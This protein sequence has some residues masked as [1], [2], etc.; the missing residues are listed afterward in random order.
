[1]LEQPTILIAMGWY[2]SR[3][4]RGIAHFAK[5]HNWHISPHL[6]SDREIPYGWR[7][8]GVLTSYSRE[9]EKFVDGLDIPYVV[10]SV[11]SMSRPAPRVTDDNQRVGQLAAEHYLERGFRHFAFFTWPDIPI[12]LARRDAYFAALRS[13]GVPAE[14]MHEILQP[15][16]EIRQDWARYQGSIIEQLQALPRPLAVF[17]SQDNMAA[18]IIDACTHNGIQVPEEIA[19]LGVDNIEFLCEC[20]A[21]PLSSIPTRQED[22]GWAAAKRLHQLMKGTITND[23]P[24]VLVPPKDVVCRRSTDVLAVEHP[25]VRQAVEFICGNLANPITLENIAACAGMSPRGLQKAFLK[26][27]GRSPADELRQCRLS[28]A[29]RLL[30]ETTDKVESIAR[31]CGYSNGANLSFALKRDCGLAARAYRNSFAPEA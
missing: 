5:E 24:P 12:N 4:F 11:V 14:A 1:M 6:F 26:H 23:A 30:M 8:D 13:A 9:Q 16:P 28:A 20:Q 22:I 15:P 29:K 2:D 25:A 31:N 19:V 3:L 17:T 27:L 21:V 10:L 7:G 18:V